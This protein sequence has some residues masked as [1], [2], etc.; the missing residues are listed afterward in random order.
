MPSLSFKDVEINFKFK[1]EIKLIFYTHIKKMTN[2]TYI[3]H[4]LIEWA[5]NENT[6]K[7]SRN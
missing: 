1:L 2:L 5:Q 3:L 7:V 4:S 6:I